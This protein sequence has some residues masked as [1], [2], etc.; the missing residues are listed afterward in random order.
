MSSKKS[1]LNGLNNKIYSNMTLQEII[2]LFL[3]EAEPYSRAPF[4][5][6]K[7]RV[8]TYCLNKGIRL[9]SFERGDLHALGYETIVYKNHVYILGYSTT[10]I[11]KE[12]KKQ[13]ITN[14]KQNANPLYT[15]FSES[16]KSHDFSKCLISGV[17]QDEAIAQ[18]VASI[19]RLRK[20]HSK[21]SVE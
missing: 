15:K 19:Q 1:V 2:P 10:K 18:S 5:T 21:V 13:G 3:T 17:S 9:V 7:K 12:M 11:T 6:I 16:N 8:E 14:A 4:E 20:K